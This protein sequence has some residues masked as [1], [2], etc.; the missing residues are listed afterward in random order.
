MTLFEVSGILGALDGI[1]G[2]LASSRIGA[3]QVAN[4]V[5]SAVSVRACVQ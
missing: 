2:G 3:T 1:T 5:N 4:E